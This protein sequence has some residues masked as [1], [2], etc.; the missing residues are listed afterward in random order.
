MLKIGDILR[1]N[2]E[3]L[4]LSQEEI[5]H[6]ICSVSNLSRIENN[7]QIPSRA[8][9]QKL[10]QR[11]GMP[12]EPYPIFTDE[13]EL[14]AYQLRRDINDCIITRRFDEAE[15]LMQK[16]ENISKLEPYYLQFIQYCR[17]LL[18]RDKGGEPSEIRDAL[19]EVADSMVPGFKPKK[20]LRHALTKDELCMLN[21]LADAYYETGEEDYGI[22]ILRAVKEY[23]EK[24]VVDDEGIT[25]I[26][27]MI[28]FNLSNWLG[29]RGQYHDVIE[30]CDI[31]IKRCIKYDRLYVFGDLIFNKGYALVMLGQKEEGG[32]YIQE[33]YYISRAKNDTRVC[34]ITKK[35]AEENNILI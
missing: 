35:F 14:E 10:M 32:K 1:I 9:Y 11:M 18:R 4:Q 26:Y 27:T 17:V 7:T 23:I 28:L 20:I 19:Q 31:G 6:G 12:M 25:N 16:M 15:T 8:T 22:E 29:K 2:R 21:N 34:E 5:C 3:Y 33:S 24:K 30:L 13:R